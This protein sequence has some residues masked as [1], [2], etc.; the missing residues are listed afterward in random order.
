MANRKGKNGSSDRLYFLELQNRCKQWLQHEIKR[1]FLLGRK[2]MTNLDSVLKT[3][4]CRQSPYHQSYGFSS[5][6]VQ[7][8][9]MDHKGGW[10]PKNWCFQIVVLE[11]IF[12]SP[13]DCKEIKPVNP[14]GNQPWIFVGRTDV[15]VEAPVLCP[16]DGKSQL[17]V[18]TLMLGRIEGKRRRGGRAFDGWVASPPQWTW[19]WA[20]SGRWW[21]TGKLAIHG[22]TKSRTQLSNWTTTTK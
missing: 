16:P 14:K 19:I 7:T 12:K 17:I 1:H 3:S 22:V 4:L 11:K 9:E 8:W 13:S 20:N 21:R 18:E 6:H 10:E 2:A 5:N 15:E